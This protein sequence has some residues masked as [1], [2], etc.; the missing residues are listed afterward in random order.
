MAEV[1]PVEALARVQ[2]PARVLRVRARITSPPAVESDSHLG[3]FARGHRFTYTDA[4]HFVW[5][6]PDSLPL[7]EGYG[8]GAYGSGPYGEAAPA[9]GYGSK[10]YGSGPYGEGLS[11]FGSDPFGRGPYGGG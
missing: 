11:G 7:M 3:G 5:W 1:P 6:T 2:P 9:T 4:A 10:S 8:G